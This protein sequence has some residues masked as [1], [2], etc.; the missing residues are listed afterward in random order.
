MAATKS[1]GGGQTPRRPVPAPGGRSQN[2]T[3]SRSARGGGAA[4]AKRT[5]FLNYP[6]AGKEG[7]SRWVPSWR[8]FALLLTLVVA[9]GAILFAVAWVTIDIPEAD[10]VAVSETTEVFYADTTTKMG[11]FA[12]FNRD[13]VPLDT[14]PAHVGNAVVASEDRRFYENNGVD[15]VGTTRAL[16]NNLQG[17]PTQGGSTLTQQYVERYYMGTTTSYVGKFKEAI[18]ALKINLEQPKEQVLENYLNT[19][20][21][22][23]GAYGIEIAAQE[24]FGK[25]AADLTLAESALLAGIIPAPSNWD[26]AKNPER[27]EARWNRVLDLMVEDGWITAEERAAQNFPT[28]VDPS[29]SDTY[30]GPQGYLLDMVR[31]ELAARADITEAEIDRAGYDIVTTIN[32]AWQQAAVDAVAALPESRPE[33]NHVGLVSVDPRTGAIVALYGG[34]DYLTRARNA[35][36]QDRAQAGSIF[37][38]FTM[39]AAL[40][41]GATLNRI[42]T[43]NSPMRIAGWGDQQVRNFLNHSWGNINMLSATANSVN[44]YYA[45]LNRDVGPEATVDAA[46]RAGIPEDTPGLEPYPS[47]VLGPSSPRPIDIARAYSTFANNGVRHEP[48]IVTTVTDRDGNV[49]YN[50]GDAGTQEFDAQVTADATYAMTRV[51]RE[52]SGS[53]VDVLGRPIAGKTGTSNDN[54]S[55]WFVGYIPQM[56]TVVAMYETDEAG[57]EAPL[58]NF[59]GVR[60]ITGSTFP[61]T[62]WRDYMRVA[63]DDMEVEQFPERSRGARDSLDREEPLR[64]PAPS[65]RPA[66][67]PAPSTAEPTPEPTAEPTEEPEEPA[68]EEPTESPAPEAPPA[69]EAPAPAPS[70]TGGTE[71]QG[72]DGQ[73]G[74]GPGNS[75]DAPQGPGN[76]NGNGGG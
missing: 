3:R 62:V 36:T 5:N 35:V 14:L 16:V 24:Y 47:N 37:K 60:G 30:A 76:N 63:T 32:P 15:L 21:F 59:G 9:A 46:V 69:T 54:R 65:R 18:L 28:T 67:A 11:E 12:E 72:D 8:I 51:I 41:E 64:R 40:E 22:G 13:S 17:K 70:P 49:I 27:A 38:P 44:T 1:T 57:N 19:I 43:S 45:Q 56:V 25:N 75:G 10:E 53:R 71:P 58:T 34:E 6:R 48:F 7:A 20:Y 66:P 39:V 55:A 52:G 61:A 73:G 2:P 4:A 31:T 26:P 23:R 50:G 29:Q 33:S 68:Q 74:G 42:Y